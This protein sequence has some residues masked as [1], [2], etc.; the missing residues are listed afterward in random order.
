VAALV[1]APVALALAACGGGSAT[2]TGSTGS[3]TTTSSS[4]TGGAASCANHC[5]DGLLDCGEIGFD[6]GGDCDACAAFD[7]ATMC[8]PGEDLPWG[9]PRLVDVRDQNDAPYTDDVEEPEVRDFGGAR[10]LLFNDEPPGGAKD[11]YVGRWD[12]AK[13]AF[14]VLGK[15]PGANTPAVDG[16]P[17]LSEDGHFYFVSTRSYPNPTETIHQAIFSVA[18][19]P[20]TAS[21]G[22]VTR[23][24]GLSR[25]DV[26]WLTQGVQITWDGAWLYFDEAKFGH[27]PPTESDIF[28]AKNTGQGFERLPPQD[29]A[30]LFANVNTPTFLE[31][32][33]TLSHDGL[34][35]YFTR[36]WFDAK[37][38]ASVVMCVMRSTRSS[39]DAPFGP[40]R[41]VAI[42]APGPSILM[43]AP[44]LSP[45]EKTLYYHRRN[46]GD[47]HTHLY[48][49]DRP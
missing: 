31:Y 19:A 28:L 35:M 11:L 1:W 34:E 49:I 24:D 2:S 27:G 10:W 16:N 6:C 33:E 43:E 36:T 9:A 44:S 48:A 3:S 4:G 18:G 5:G 21:I 46:P 25:T 30:T 8:G 40:A 38:L 22:M 39:I 15:L 20:P 12:D 17:S 47:A 37:N 7:V 32:A 26:P 41:N 23:L 29:Q 45:D 13:K 42:T 14:V